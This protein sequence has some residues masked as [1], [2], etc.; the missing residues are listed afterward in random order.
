MAVK[1]AK[2]NNQYNVQRRTF[3]IDSADDLESVEVEYDCGIGDL[4]EL[5][6]GTVYCRHSDGYDGDLWEVKSSGGNSTPSPTPSPNSGFV[7]LTLTD[8]I[9]EHPDSG[10]DNWYDLDCSFADLQS[11]VNSHQVPIFMRIVEAQDSYDGTE[12]MELYTL[13]YLQIAGDDGHGSADAPYWAIFNNQ[14]S[15]IAFNAIT[16]Y[17]MLSEHI[18]GYDPLME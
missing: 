6:D 1:L 10:Y 9:D 5:P 15:S 7:W 12:S 2:K 14:S 4:A 16:P 11:F 3:Y 13:S 17:D 18:E 8:K